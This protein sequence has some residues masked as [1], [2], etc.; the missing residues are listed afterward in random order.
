MID[1]KIFTYEGARGE[2]M[3]Q[4]WDGQGALS[5]QKNEKTTRKVPILKSN[6]QYFLFRFF[7]LR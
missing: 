3:G 7:F 4:A 1:I 2:G 6:F 5:V